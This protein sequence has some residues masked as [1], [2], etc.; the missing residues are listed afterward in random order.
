[1]VFVMRAAPRLGRLSQTL[2]SR[3]VKLI[4]NAHSPRCNRV[5]TSGSQGSIR[6]SACLAPAKAAA[7]A[8]A[9]P[10]K[11][12][13]CADC[14]RLSADMQLGRRC[15]CHDNVSSSC[16]FCVTWAQTVQTAGL[17][18]SMQQAMA[19][20]T[21]RTCPSSGSCQRMCASFSARTGDHTHNMSS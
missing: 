19:L 11:P 21:R 4:S 8:G 9:I 17:G 6:L 16:R 12:V 5:A 15:L 3:W 13:C 10:C 20:T 2:V 18:G 7:A 1:M 14:A